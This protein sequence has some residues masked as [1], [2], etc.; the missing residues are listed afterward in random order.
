MNGSWRL[1]TDK[2]RG[3][4]ARIGRDQQAG[5]EMMETKAPPTRSR[6]RSPKVCQGVQRNNINRNLAFQY[7]EVD[8]HHHVG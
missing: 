7:W 4:H 6:L 1:A 8:E 3:S 5:I 2:G